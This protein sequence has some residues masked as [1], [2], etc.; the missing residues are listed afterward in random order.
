MER[1]LGIVTPVLHQCAPA[2]L[3]HTPS[4]II[5]IISVLLCHRWRAYRLQAKSTLIDLDW[6]Q[7]SYMH[8]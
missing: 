4:Q 3:F 7:N 6:Q 8:P 1:Q 2:Q 5:I